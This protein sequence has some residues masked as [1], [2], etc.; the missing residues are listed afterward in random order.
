M[1]NINENENLVEEKVLKGIRIGSDWVLRNDTYNLVLEQYGVKVNP[2][3]KEGEIKESYG[4]ISKTYHRTLQ[5]ALNHI[6][7]NTMYKVDLTDLKK[8]NAEIVKLQNSIVEFKKIVR[9]KEDTLEMID[10]NNNFNRK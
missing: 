10:E 8:V 4:L 7:N 3:A 1:E 2:R 5:Q 6:I 9:L